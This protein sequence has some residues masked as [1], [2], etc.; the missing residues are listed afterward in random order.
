[1]HKDFSHFR[2]VVEQAIGKVK[3]F[4]ACRDRI[5]MKPGK[6]QDSMKTQHQMCWTMGSVFVNE[7]Y[8]VKTI[9]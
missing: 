3:T 7:F 4:A 5:R 8:Q 1:M 6:N 2:I 9:N